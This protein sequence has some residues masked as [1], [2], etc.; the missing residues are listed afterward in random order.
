M[1]IHHLFS[2]TL[3]GINKI[4][5]IDG[6]LISEIIIGI[7]CTHESTSIMSS[8]CLDLF[9]FDEELLAPCILLQ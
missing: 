7:F 6:M 2:S 8:T 3:D 9:E 4:S 1:I 5:I